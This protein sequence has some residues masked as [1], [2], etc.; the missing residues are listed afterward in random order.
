NHLTYLGDTVV[1]RKVNV[2]AGTVTCNYEGGNEFRTEIE[3]GA[4]IGSGTMLVAPVKIG[5]G[6]TI[7]A[8]S[9]RPKDAPPEKLTLARARQT[10]VEGWRRPAKKTEE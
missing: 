3:D 6:A 4:F 1:A 5:T 9:T 8:G 7:G 10:T 2:G